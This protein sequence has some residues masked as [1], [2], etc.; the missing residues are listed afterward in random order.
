MT[1]K[2]NSAI[3]KFHVACFAV[4]LM[5][6]GCGGNDDA[7]FTPSVTAPMAQAG[8]PFIVSTLVDGQVVS[9]RTYKVMSVVDDQGTLSDQPL[10]EEEEK[11]LPHVLALQESTESAEE[12]SAYQFYRDAGTLPRLMPA[13]SLRDVGECHKELFAGIKAVHPTLQTR[14]QIAQRI[15][16]LDMTVDDLCTLIPSSGLS[17]VDYLRLMEKVSAYWPGVSNID[18]RVAMFFLNIQARPVTFEKALQD[19]GYSWDAFLQ[20]VSGR[21]NGLE[22]FY[23]LLEK[24]D[25][26]LQPFLKDYMAT[27]ATQA[28]LMRVAQTQFAKW[29]SWL[30]D[31]I[32]PSAIAQTNIVDQYTSKID[33]IFE[34][35]KT[36]WAVVEGSVG[37]ANIDDSKLQ[38]SLVS[39]KDKNTINYYGAKESRSATVSFVGKT[40]AFELWENYRVDMV[41]VCDYD[42]RHATVKGQWIPNMGIATPV[43][44]ASWGFGKG[45]KV[46]G[47]ATVA[48]ALNRGTPENP[49]PSV[50]MKLELTAIAFTT[51]RKSYVF[52]CRG[53]TGV[54]FKY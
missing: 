50:D 1:S 51:V 53:D 3:P 46:N 30:V 39:A 14:D 42:G 6:A 22:E 12:R 10:P 24:S 5:V 2:L 28:S 18:G 48:N 44:N 45:Y 7:V 49:I 29:A 20:R 32:V 17:V 25:L 54:S 27:T 52:N 21:K 47:T 26:A 36:V 8:Q 23:A 37:S 43:V 19:N 16:D 13:I 35:V 11:K 31:R 15:A 33:K 34:I 40:Y 9:E 4:L 38:N 41:A